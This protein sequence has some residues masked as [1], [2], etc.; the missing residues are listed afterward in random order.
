MAGGRRP[1]ARAHPAPRRARQ[2]LGHGHPRPRRAVLGDL[3][4]PR[5]RAR[6][7][8]RPGGRRGPL[9]RDLEP[10]LHAGHPRR[11]EPEVRSRPHRRAPAEEHR[12]RARRRARRVPAPGRGERLRDRPA[13]PGD[14]PRAGALGPLLR[15]GDRGAGRPVPGHRRPRPHRRHAHRRR[16]RA[17]QRGSRLRAAPPTASR[18][19]QRPAARH[20]RA[21]ARRPRRHRAR[22][23][24]SV[25]PGDRHLLRA[26]RRRGAPRGGGLPRHARHRLADLRVG[27]LRR[28]GLRLDDVAR[29]QRLRPAR[30]LRLPHRPDAGDGLGGRALGRR[31]RLPRR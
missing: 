17:R 24:G 19:A 2:L 28:P 1:A 6:A 11:G 23:H 3:L 9:P 25:V 21:G 8:G 26:D 15:R 13:A 10:R 5:S 29:V 31:G 22:R 12:H 30:H 18:R 20:H 4:R 7:R 14:R 27:G 16:R